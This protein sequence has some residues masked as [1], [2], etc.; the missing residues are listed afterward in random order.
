[1][2]ARL[3]IDSS[4]Y[5][6]KVKRAAEGILHLERTIREAGESF[7]QTWKDEQ[8]FAKGLGQME[9]V[10]KTAR[11]KISELTSAFTEMSLVYKRMTDEEKNS[12]FGQGLKG[13]LDQL[14]VRIAE[15]KS[16]LADVTKEL[17]NLGAEGED[18]G[19]ILGTLK[20]KLTINIDAMKLFEVGLKAGSAALG[21]AKDAFFASEATVDEWGRTMASAQSLYE[22]FLTA[23]NTGDISGY[24]NNISQIVAAAREAYNE[25]DTLQTMQTIQTPAKSAKETEIQRMRTMLMTGIYIKPTD[26]K[27]M[28]V[29]GRE[30]Q[31][32]DKLSPAQLKAIEKSLQSAIKDIVTITEREVKQAN[33]HIDAYYNKLAKENGISIEEFRKGTSNWEEFTKRIKG[34]EDYRKFEAAHTTTTT[35]SL[36]IVHS[37][38]DAV[39]N[40]HEQYKNWSVFRVDKM[41]ENSFNDMVGYI[42]QRDQKKSQL[43]SLI[44]QTYRTTNRLEGITPRNLLKGAGGS[45]SGNGPT[46]NTTQ[47]LTPLQ[48]VQK[49]ITDL[50]NEAQTADKERQDEIKGQITLLQKEADE[51]KKIDDYVRGITKEAKVPEMATGFAGLSNASLSAWTN[52]LKQQLDQAELGSTLYQSLSNQ[53]ADATAI[54]N[55]ISISIKQGLDLSAV[56]LG[57]GE[58]EGFWSSILS[59]EDI[60]DEQLQEIVNKMNQFMGDHPIKLNVNTGE[61]SAENPAHVLSEVGKM[62]SGISSIVSGIESLGVKIPNGLKAVISGIQGIMSI[63]TGISSMITAIQTLSA[64]SSFKFFSG[65]GI[66]GKAAG[67]MVIP[68][69]SFSGDNLRM[70]VWDTGGMI[71]VNSGE[72]ILNRAQA[73]IIASELQGGAQQTISSTP[74]VSGEQIYL[75]LSNYLRRTGR[76][77]LLTAR[78]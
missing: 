77:E 37:Y 64:A 76:G 59:A 30:M 27:G 7:I 22:G 51:Y 15:E 32:G 63:L 72:V 23:L 68:G 21:V 57:A 45:G 16:D 70:P 14:K 5:D 62:T 42:Q 56:G 34:A 40:P 8:E 11:G 17:N 28:M 44:G 73:G 67:G 9:T 54:S 24:L 36:G 31:T 20:D 39:A 43:Y 19:G 69:S 66:V 46:G 65:G 35:S 3:K 2:I 12:P 29:N 48:E 78:G 74:Y 55:L 38:R 18:T 1:M 58:I 6:S 53:L 50:A 75:G 47:Q 61:V 60:T 71:G 41:G 4:E 33:K 13:S 49:R 52:G 26:R 25:L 10:S